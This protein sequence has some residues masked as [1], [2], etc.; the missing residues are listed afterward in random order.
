MAFLHRIF[1]AFEKKT[2]IGELWRNF[3][4]MG[5][6]GATMSLVSAFPSLTF[7]SLSLF[8]LL[9]SSG[10]RVTFA[11]WP[12]KREEGEGKK[13]A[14]IFI[15]ETPWRVGGWSLEAA[16]IGHCALANEKKP[17]LI[18]LVLLCRGGDAIQCYIGTRPSRVL[19]WFHTVSAS[20]GDLS[21]RGTFRSNRE[22]FERIV[23]LSVFFLSLF[24]L[25]LFSPSCFHGKIST[26][27]VK[28]NSTTT[29]RLVNGRNSSGK[30]GRL[31]VQNTIE[32]ARGFRSRACK[33]T[34][35]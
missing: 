22:L 26:S 14:F 15:V 23:A 21:R 17:W 29:A 19:S 35:N 33:L 3:C 32:R 25:I 27:P 20:R 12:R 9:P 10:K 4:T 2:Q 5:N 24:F 34:N 11:L 1:V 28:R 13:V 16:D 6:R 31:F 18:L 8:S 30:V 7:I